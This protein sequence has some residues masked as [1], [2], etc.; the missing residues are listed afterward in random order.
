MAKIKVILDLKPPVNQKQIK[1]FLGHTGYYRKFIRHY[2][3]ITFPIDELLKKE[4]EFYWSQECNK[5]FEILKIKLVEAPILRFPDWS[6]KFHVH[7]DA[8]NV[9]V[10]SV[11]AQPY[12]DLIDHPNAYASRK[13][14]KEEINYS[15]TEHEALAMIFSLQKFRHYL[16]ANPFIFFTDHQALKYLVN[17]PVHQGKMCRWLLLFQEFDFEVIVRPGKKN[18]GPDHLSRLETGEDLTGIE[19]DFPDANLFRVE[20][21]PKELEEIANF[22]EEGKAPDDLPT[23]KWKILAMK[24]APFTL[25]NGYLYK[26][27][28]DNILRR[29]ALEHEREDIITE[30]HAGPTGGHFQAD[31]TTRKILQAGLWW[32]TLHKYCQEKIKKCD[33]CQRIGRPLWK[34]EIPLHSV[35]P[36]LP[37]EIWAIDFVRPFPKRDKRMGGKYIITVVE[38]LTKWVKQNQS[39]IVQRKQP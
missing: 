14:N 36:N 16:L 9:V 33:K 11:L 10:G 34:N 24:V 29:C 22:L 35:N 1:I 6:K 18:V 37:F 31:T 5:S 20:A 17:K 23:N 7:V 25:M 2:S 39:R 3:D 28:L 4:V 8:S 19:D 32:P 15:T 27:G 30:A 12:D 13:L 26:L 21:V 38:Y